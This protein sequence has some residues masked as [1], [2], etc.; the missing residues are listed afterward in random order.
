MVKEII[1]TQGKI[2]IVDDKDFDEL[3]KFTWC[4]DK[5]KGKWYATRGVWYP[6]TKTTR[7]IRMHQVIMKDLYNEHRRYTDHINTDTLD[8]RRSNLRVCTNSEN[9]RN[10]RKSNN[11]SGYIGVTWDKNRK[12]WLAQIGFHWQHIFIGRYDDIIEAA[13]AVDN[14]AWELFGEYALLNFPGGEHGQG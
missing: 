5:V 14:K 3:I 13:R 6:L 1:L 12:K 11:T 4:A 10:C 7:K 8:N 9:M 2:A